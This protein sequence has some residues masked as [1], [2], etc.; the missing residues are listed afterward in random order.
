MESLNLDEKILNREKRACFDFFWNET[1]TDKSSK[2]FGLMR[3]N[4]L[5][6]HE[7]MC[8]IAS[9]GF[10]LG[11]IVIGVENGYISRAEAQAR[12]LGTLKT[13]RNQAE[14]EHGFFYHFL[15]LHT[16]LKNPNFYDVPSIIDSSIL[17][18]GMIVAGEYFGG[19]IKSIGDEIIARA[20]W[21]WYVN[22][23]NKTF[24]MGFKDGKGF[25][26][27]DM[28]AEQLMQ[29][30]LAAGSPTFPIESAVYDSWS[31]E[32]V[33]YEGYEFMTAPRNALF[34]HQYSHAWFDFSSVLDKD[35]IDFA[36]NSRQATLASRAYA[37][38]KADTY[39]TFNE[40]SWGQA[41]CEG[42]YGYRAYGSGYD[43]ITDEQLEQDG[44]V[45]PT[46]ASGSLV[47]TPEISLDA[48]NY[49][50]NLAGVWGKYGL[51]DA[52][53]F[54]VEPAYYAKGFIGIDKGITLLMIENY[55]TGLIWKLYMQNEWIKKG[56]ERLG[57][58]KK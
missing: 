44:T 46:A 30:L 21:N 23:E 29:Y 37:I 3:D 10:G 57:F 42:P 16:G 47:F 8:S 19:E 15:D 40:H 52:Y 6:M 25:G 53:N 9:N 56:A 1:N 34:T 20:D 58:V 4:T 38:N 32:K 27:W 50:A 17:F 51:I 2:G 13:F 39:K 54:D 36:E 12:V 49:M 28:Y 24:Y 33:T 26:A 35:G 48:M 11:A 22:P 7:N 5:K 55:Q 41:A 43:G 18:N 45:A 14:H 31:R